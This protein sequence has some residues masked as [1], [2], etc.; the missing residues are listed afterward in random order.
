MRRYRPPGG[1][2]R[3]GRR[4][5]R[6]VSPPA[7]AHAGPPARGAPGL[8]AAGTETT[9]SV[10]TVTRLAASSVGHKSVTA[11]P[12]RRT[13]LTV[14]RVCNNVTEGPNDVLLDRSGSGTRPPGGG[15]R[16]AL[17]ADLARPLRRL[18]GLCDRNGGCQSP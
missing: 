11:G 12:I 16:A 14:A 6:R 7:Y 15:H 3:C 9:G 8:R 13:V 17:P 10:T 18:S 2:R 4:Y 1:R 5:A